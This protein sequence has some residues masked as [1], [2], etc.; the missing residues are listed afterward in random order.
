MTRHNSSTSPSEKGWRTL[1]LKSL[2]L[3]LAVTAALVLIGPVIRKRTVTTM[4][5]DGF[6]EKAAEEN[7]D[8]LMLGSSQS[9]RGIDPRLFE[10]QLET[11]AYNLSNSAQVLSQTRYA[12]EE[13]LRH[14]DPQVVILETYFINQADLLEDRWYFAYEEVAAMRPGLPRFRYIFDLFTPMTYLDALFPAIREHEN[15]SDEETLEANRLYAETGA[16]KEKANL[17][18]GY[19]E[20]ESVLSEIHLAEYAQLPYHEQDFTMDEAALRHLRAIRDLCDAHGITLILVKTAMPKAHT[21]R[22]NEADRHAMTALVAEELD[23]PFI[24]FNLLYD[25]LGFTNA[26][27][28]DE[29][30]ETNHHL[31]SSGARLTTLYLVDYLRSQGTFK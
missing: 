15:W 30:S 25:T 3:L 23:L 22:T 24:D 2:L 6:Y 31:N 4:R 18:L 7:I 9:F 26:Q 19:V 8:I 29:F 16:S 17:H 20:D 14:T 10:E 12:L 5:W 21:D 13:A 1:V 27:F 11:T 28:R